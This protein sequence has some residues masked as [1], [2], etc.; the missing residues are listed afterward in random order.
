MQLLAEEEKP[1]DAR[2]GGAE[3][4]AAAGAFAAPPRPCDAM[5]GRGRTVEEGADIFKARW[6]HEKEEGRRGDRV[7]SANRE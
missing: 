7:R 5:S 3:G 4:A 2:S 1:S 6:T